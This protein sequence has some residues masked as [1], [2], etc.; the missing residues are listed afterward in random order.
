[1]VKQNNIN[2]LNLKLESLNYKVYEAYFVSNRKDKPM[3]ARE[4]NSTPNSISSIVCVLNKKLRQLNGDEL[5]VE[6]VPTVRTSREILPHLELDFFEE[7]EELYIRVKTSVEFENYLKSNKEVRETQNLWKKGLPGKYYYLSFLNNYLDDIN[8]PIIYKNQIN[9]AML[10][11]V[12]ISEGKTFKVDG[13]IQEKLIIAGL[14]KFKSAF[15]A[16]YKT[17]IIGNKINLR[18]EVS[19]EIENGI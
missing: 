11:V 17:N 13:L 9:A 10:R 14:K 19:E 8:Q 4:L 7:N 12:G 6:R 3:L 15:S 1:M 5:D 16:F 18:L 2:P